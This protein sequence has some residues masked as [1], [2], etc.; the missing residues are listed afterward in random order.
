MALSTVAS[1]PT[2]A[3]ESTHGAR[4]GCWQVFWAV[5][6]LA[7]S[8]GASCGPASGLRRPGRGLT[9]LGSRPNGDAAESEG[10]AT[11]HLGHANAGRIGRD[12]NRV[13][14]RQ[15]D[16]APVVVVWCVELHGERTG[17]SMDFGRQGTACGV[18]ESSATVGEA[19][20]A[21]RT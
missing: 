5:R 7:S 20:E 3:S 15:G 9:F 14:V 4:D 11:E 13:P 12:Q 1:D 10:L 21:S 18:A 16:V 17:L 2:G 6:R 19:P 8:P